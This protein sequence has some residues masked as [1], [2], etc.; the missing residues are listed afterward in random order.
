MSLPVLYSFR[1]CPYAIRA[2]YALKYA[3]I[4][5]VL[6]EINLK[7]KPDVLLSVSPKGTV[8][9]LVLPNGEVLDESI[10]I[11]QWALKQRGEDRLSPELEAKAHDAIRYND[12]VFVKIIHRYKYRD[13][14]PPETFSDNENKLYEHLES[15]DVE[16]RSKPFL[17]ADSLTRVDIAV[18]PFVR[19]VVQINRE[20]FTHPSLARLMHWLDNFLHTPLFHHVMTS[21]K[22]W[23]PNDEPVIF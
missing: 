3:G 4:L 10:E 18:F 14:Y 11:V 13:L 19:Q 7:Q 12:T 17:L 22:V 1:R 23:A 21:Y 6:R 15:L 20:Q 2:R 16:L 5:C 9:V 8:P